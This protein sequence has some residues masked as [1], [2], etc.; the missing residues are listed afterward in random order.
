[1][2]D[3]VD[4]SALTARAGALVDA[5]RRAGA[6]HADAVAVRGIGDDPLIQYSDPV[7]LFTHLNE[8]PRADAVNGMAGLM[9]WSQ[10]PTSASVRYASA[11]KA[12]KR[13][14]CLRS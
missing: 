2:T 1:M 12:A 4:L 14:V 7:K 3:L 11:A 10:A 6:D 13:S 5:A 9:A 8:V